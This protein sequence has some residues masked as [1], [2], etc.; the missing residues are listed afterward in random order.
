MGFFTKQPPEIEWAYPFEG[1]VSMNSWKWDGSCLSAE[2]TLERV[3]ANYPLPPTYSSAGYKSLHC[4]FEDASGRKLGDMSGKFTIN[5]NIK[6]LELGMTG[7]CY[8]DVQSRGVNPREVI[9]VS[10][11]LSTA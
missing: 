4:V 2:L 3:P 8:I 9:R 6:N 11:H 7:K 1:C 5:G 10:M